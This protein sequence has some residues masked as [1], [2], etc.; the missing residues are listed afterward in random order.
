MPSPSFGVLFQDGES[1]VA[2]STPNIARSVKKN[3]RPAEDSFFAGRVER[4]GQRGANCTPYKTSVREALNVLAS[5]FTGPKNN[6]KL[7][8]YKAS[9]CG[10]LGVWASS[11]LVQ[12]TIRSFHTW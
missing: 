3:S 9:V 1:R 6:Q 5:K 10:A 7:T 2:S 11:S 12:K 8:W 4:V